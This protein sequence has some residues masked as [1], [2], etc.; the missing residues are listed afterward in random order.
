MKAINYI[1]DIIEGIYRLF[2]GMYITMLNMLRKKVTEQYPENRGKHEYPERFRGML[3]LIYD[4]KNEHKCT[5]C[6]ICAINCPN[7][8]L[9]VTVKKEVDEATG[10]EKRVLDNYMYDLGACIFCSRCVQT[11][12]CEA[13][14]WT[15]HFEHSVFNR[16]KLVKQL[17]K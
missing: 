13:I 5:G 17:N 4:E 15:N 1:K 16:N 10:K 7:G 11:C 3:R 2:Q 14:G 6:G 12:P 8:T 9:K